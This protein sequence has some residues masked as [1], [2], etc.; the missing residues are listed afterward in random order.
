MRP[1][2][3]DNN[4]VVNANNHFAL[5]VQTLGVGLS[6]AHAGASLAGIMGQAAQK[7]VISDILDAGDRS[8]RNQRPNQSE[9]ATTQKPQSQSAHVLK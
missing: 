7:Q 3:L 5:F 4:V 8:G 6:V 9:N 1:K 2:F